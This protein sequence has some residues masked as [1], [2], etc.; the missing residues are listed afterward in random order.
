MVQRGG[1]RNGECLG[2]TARFVG[3][4]QLVIAYFK[5]DPTEISLV[6]V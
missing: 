1:R 6:G 5:P 2:K 3:G 4:V